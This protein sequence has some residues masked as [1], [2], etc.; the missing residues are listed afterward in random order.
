MGNM[1]ELA[2]DQYDEYGRAGREQNGA[3]TPQPWASPPPIADPITRPPNT[4][5]KLT[6]PTRPWAHWE[7]LTDRDRGGPPNEGVCSEK[8][9]VAIA[10]I[11]FVVSAR[12]KWVSVSIMR[13]IRIRSP[14]LKRRVSQP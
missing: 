1:G 3:V 13:P 7:P 8:K 12:I 4:P 6:E 11:G 5:T 14:R 10:T 9:N 2:P